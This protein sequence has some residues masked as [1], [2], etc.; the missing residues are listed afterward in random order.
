[1]AEC[2]GFD[3]VLVRLMERRGLGATA[4]AGQTGVPEAEVRAVLSGAT[5]GE[6]QLRRLAPALGMHEADLLAIAWIDVPKDLAPLDRR[7]SFCLPQMVGHAA[8]LPPEQVRGLRDSVNRMPQE[9]RPQPARPPGAFERFERLSR[10]PGGLLMRLF[11][12]RNLGSR[13]A[14]AI[15]AVAWRGL[16]PSTV[17]MAGHGRKDLSGEE[18]ADYISVLDIS[19]AE[20]SVVTGADL[21]APARRRPPGT[22]EAARLLWDVRR[23]SDGQV[24]HVYEMVK[25]YRREP[26]QALAPPA[27]AADP[28]S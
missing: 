3:V 25:S 9:E 20:M 15:T 11:A 4:L 21:P 13:A 10:T 17:W 16:S 28:S 24:R 23:L 12:N 27:S 14:Y 2:P 26:G 5:P 8:R 6:A 7:A 1:M 22:T 18:L 19:A